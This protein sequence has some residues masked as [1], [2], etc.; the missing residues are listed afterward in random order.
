M[1]WQP[2]KT[3]PRNKD[4]WVGRFV[5][6]EWRMCVSGLYYDS[7][8]IVDGDFP[9]WYWSTDY[10]SCGATDDEGPTHWMPLPKPPT[11]TE[12]P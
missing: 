1:N 9:Y 11:E 6:N 8:N 3:A 7:G 5:N 12:E 4:L 2:I 10:D